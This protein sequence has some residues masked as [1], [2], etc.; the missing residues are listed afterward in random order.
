MTG[1]GSALSVVARVAMMPGFIEN[2]KVQ[3]AVTESV[4]VSMPSDPGSLGFDIPFWAGLGLVGLWAALDAF[5]ER[6]RLTKRCPTCRSSCIWARLKQYVGPDDGIALKELED[7]RH[8]YAHNYAGEADAEYF[9]RKQRHV[10][11]PGTCMILSCGARFDGYR[12]H[13]N[14]THLKAYSSAV[15]RVLNAFPS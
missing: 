2:P 13:L 12:P 4:P 1:K 7:L 3:Q 8:L 6:E 5:A 11:R 15:T 10:L 9:E 14:L